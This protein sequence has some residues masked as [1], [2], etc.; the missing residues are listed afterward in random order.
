MRCSHCGREVMPTIH[1][2][3]GYTV[4]YYSLITGNLVPV[5][6]DET[7]TGEETFQ[8]YKIEQMIELITCVSCWKDPEIKK[9]IAAEF[10]ECGLGG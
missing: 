6:L 4:D 5:M 2:K 7:E 3:D 9:R 10:G 8:Y 1:T